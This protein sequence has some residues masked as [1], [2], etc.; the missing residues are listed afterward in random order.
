M[1]MGQSYTNRKRFVVC[2]CPF[3]GVRQ[4]KTIGDLDDNRETTIVLCSCGKSFDL[5][6]NCRK[7]FRKKTYS[8]G[9][10]KKLTTPQMTDTMLVLDIS[11]GGCRFDASISHQLKVGDKI[12]I[13]LNL[14]NASDLLVKKKAI[15]QNVE[16]E[17]IGCEF[18]QCHGSIIGTWLSISEPREKFPLLES[19]STRSAPTKQ[20]FEGY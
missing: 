16:G 17:Y 14:G 15:V 11:L 2:I 20:R 18:I 19:Y 9:M 8:E 13:A 12:V 1:S 4:E 3:C 6:I 7:Y 10:Y 5:S